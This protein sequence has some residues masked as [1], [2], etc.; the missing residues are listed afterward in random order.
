MISIDYSLGFQTHRAAE[1]IKRS[2][3]LWSMSKKSEMA[4]RLFGTGQAQVQ[5]HLYL[6]SDF[7][8]EVD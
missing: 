1:G 2:L 4:A 6:P 3:C 5:T 7:L 8:Q